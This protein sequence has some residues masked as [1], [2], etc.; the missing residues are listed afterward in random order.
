MAGHMPI[1]H[2][3]C[4]DSAG[5]FCFRCR[6]VIL[7]QSLKFACALSILQT[8]R[9]EIVAVAFTGALHASYVA[10]PLFYLGYEVLRWLQ[11][12]TTSEAIPGKDPNKS[13]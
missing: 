12:M 13:G 4:R 10:C 2:R 3:H 1:L 5:L 7:M 9:L 11:P 6:G 8:G